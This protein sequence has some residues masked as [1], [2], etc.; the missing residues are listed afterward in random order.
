MTRIELDPQD[1]AELKQQSAEIRHLEQRV[2]KA[3]AGLDKLCQQLQDATA[4]LQ[5]QRAGLAEARQQFQTLSSTIG[6]PALQ[7]LVA[8]SS[9]RSDSGDAALGPR[10][11]TRWV[12]GKLVRRDRSEADLSTLFTAELGKPADTLLGFLATSKYFRKSGKPG[13]FC[14]SISKNRLNDLRDYLA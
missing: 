10:E 3:E 13:E 14:W 12:Y 2:I 1:L 9:S 11:K 6:A 4:K 5:D 7:S 8:A